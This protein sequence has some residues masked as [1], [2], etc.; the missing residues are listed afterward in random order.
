VNTTT[1]S[2]DLHPASVHS[3]T[4][5]IVPAATVRVYKYM[6]TKWALAVL[7]DRRLKM[8]VLNRTND[9][10]D[11]RTFDL[12][13]R[14]IRF[15]VEKSVQHLAQL[16]AMVCFSGGWNN[17]EGWRKY[18]DKYR[19]LCLAFD[20]DSNCVDRVEYID[21]PRVIDPENINL[22]LTSQFLFTKF[23]QWSKEDEVR[24]F[25]D[26]ADW[27]GDK[28]FFALGPQCALREVIVGPRATV[29]DS[30][31]NEHLGDM[32]DL[33]PVRHV[34]FQ[35]NERAVEFCRFVRNVT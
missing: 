21:R 22:E 14:R 19:G 23:R 18:A 8:S 32:Q 35:E 20:I 34:Q 16:K 13:N 17:L 24:A 4:T 9:A 33:V 29:L 28:C 11:L 7:K 15:M 27:E 5:T 26:I 25:V 30:T 10:Y 3:A 12:R 6:E 2:S 31:I 1:V